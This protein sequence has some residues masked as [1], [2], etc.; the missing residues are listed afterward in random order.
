MAYSWFLCVKY[1]WL[2][3][4]SWLFR[5]FS[6][7]LNTPL[8]L[9]SAET[10]LFENIL[11]N[12]CAKVGN[13]GSD[14]WVMTN[15]W[16]KGGRPCKESSR[17]CMFNNA[18]GS[19]ATTRRHENIAREQNVNVA[20]KS[21]DR[22][23]ISVID[24]EEKWAF[25]GRILEKLHFSQQFFYVVLLIVNS[26]KIRRNKQTNQWVSRQ[27]IDLSKYRNTQLW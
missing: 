16:G 19:L 20:P 7:A 3:R 8:V 18:T 26:V 4:I 21:A 11:T 14:D 12:T 24:S 22:L 13:F 5:V 6:W 10:W 15:P 17:A 27:F 2:A 23:P 9:I 25:V 1:T